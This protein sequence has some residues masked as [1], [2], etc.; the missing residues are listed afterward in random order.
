MNAKLIVDMLLESDLASS[1]AKMSKSGEVR[2]VYGG[3]SQEHVS[4]SWNPRSNEWY[5]DT[6]EFDFGAKTLEELEK[7]LTRIGATRL[8]GIDKNR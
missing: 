2:Y 1:L 5:G 7:K 6:G 4:V 3:D 8:V